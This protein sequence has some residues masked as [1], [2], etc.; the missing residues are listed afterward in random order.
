MPLHQ[1]KEIN[2]KTKRR[3]R[4][5]N[6]FLHRSAETSTRFKS[7]SY[8]L[9]LKAQGQQKPAKC[10]SC[11]SKNSQTSQVSKMSKNFCQVTRN[12]FHFALRPQIQG[13]LNSEQL[14]ISQR[15]GLPPVAEKLRVAKPGARRSHL[16]SQGSDLPPAFTHFL[17]VTMP[18]LSRLNQGHF[19]G[20]LSCDRTGEKGVVANGEADWPLGKLGRGPK[21]A[22]MRVTAGRGGR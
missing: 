18:T 2:K 21:R 10:C 11:Y 7:Q 8:E 12:N 3:N 15:S 13:S 6:F 20:R 16:I 5:L 19:A 9:Q 17:A 14:T 1:I 22:R 4:K